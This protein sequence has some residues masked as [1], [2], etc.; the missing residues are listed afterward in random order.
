[1]ILIVCPK[2][3]CALRVTGDSGEVHHLV[4]QKSYFWPDKFQCFRCSGTSIGCLEL[5]FD[6][7]TPLE[8][9]EV[10]AQEAFAALHGLGLPSE[11]QCQSE[12]IN[13]LLREQP[14]RRLVAKNV[15]GS[16]RCLV[17]YLELWDGSKVYFGSGAEGALIYKVTRPHSY[18]EQVENGSG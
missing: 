2:C 7:K 5:E 3:C 10:S 1:M 18:V 16:S 6:Q 8:V 13:E 15:A 9:V 11:Q 12:T 17:D 4:G 14:V